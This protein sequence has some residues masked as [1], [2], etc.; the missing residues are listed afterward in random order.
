MM[1]CKKFWR[2]INEHETIYKED[3]QYYLNIYLF[4]NKD[5]IPPSK[6]NRIH[7]CPFCGDEVEGGS[8]EV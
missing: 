1:C 4:N 7:Y 2:A 6:R 3:G 5:G 8:D